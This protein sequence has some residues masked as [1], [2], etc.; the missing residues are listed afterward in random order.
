[1]KAQVTLTSDLEHLGV[2]V[3]LEG[4]AARD[5]DGH[6]V[7]SSIIGGSRTVH[8]APRGSTTF[9]I[10]LNPKV[11]RPPLFALPPPGHEEVQVTL[12]FAQSAHATPTKVLEDQLQVDTEVKVDAP[13][14]V[15]V[16]RA[17]G[18][19]WGR[20]FFELFVLLVL[21]LV[22]FKLYW[23]FV[24]KAPMAGRLVGLGGATGTIVP[25]HG[26]K[27]KVTASDFGRSG[28]TT[29]RL[30]ARRGKAGVVYAERVGIDGSFERKAKAR[31]KP[32]EAGASLGLSE[33]RLDG[34]SGVRFRFS[35]G[36]DDE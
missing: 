25:L 31:W 6:R 15:I 2:D 36:G 11:A 16:G 20:F 33:Y 13:D 19:T 9:E 12:D 14:P 10:I 24:R 26:K 35:K 27:M 22:L 28:A 23:R 30:F 4:V 1:V 3:D 18:K 7:R 8:L 34:D 21:V 5:F 17:T 32:V 29:V